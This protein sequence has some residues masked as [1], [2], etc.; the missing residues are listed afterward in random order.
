M[1]IS[2]KSPLLI[3]L[4]L[5]FSTQA[6]A[7]PAPPPPDSLTKTKIEKLLEDEVVSPKIIDE[8]QTKAI[9]LIK[10]VGS[11]ANDQIIKETDKENA[12]YA[13]NGFIA[14][15]QG[16]RE[17]RE[18]LERKDE[19]VSGKELSEYSKKLDQL[20]SDIHTFFKS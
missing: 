19:V 5:S 12:Q 1:K 10:I 8:K 4:I 11:F 16:I 18:A 17:D 13:Y 3:F 14:R 6:W 15:F 7:L 20:I 9:G 2:K